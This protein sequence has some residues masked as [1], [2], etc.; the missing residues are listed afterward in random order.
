MSEAIQEKVEDKESKWLKLG[1]I[2]GVFGVKGWLKVYANT[3]K[4][5]N[6]LSY[7]PWYIERNKVRQAVK[8]KAGKPHGKTIIVQLDGVDDRNEAELWVGSDIYMKSDQLP[9]LAKDEYYWSDLIGLQVVSTDGEVFGVIDQMLETGAND[10]IVVKGER[11][12]LI[13]YVTE[14]VVK[15]VDLD[16]QKILVDWDADF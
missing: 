3:D 8:L 11:E 2:S 12:R 7:Q 5:E 16:K 6:I 4:K 15:S 9:K 14:Q 1:N 10:V 13:P